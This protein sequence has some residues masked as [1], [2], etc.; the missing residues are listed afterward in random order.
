MTHMAEVSLTGH[1]YINEKLNLFYFICISVKPNRKCHK[2]TCLI[3]IYIY[4]AILE[5]NIVKVI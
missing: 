5:H 4:C 2:Q 3:V 1:H